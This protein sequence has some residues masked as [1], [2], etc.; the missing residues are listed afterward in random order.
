MHLREVVRDEDVDVAINVMLESFI[1]SQKFSVAKMIRS[2][3]NNY[4]TKPTDNNY[5]LYKILNKIQK[6]H[7]IWSFIQIIKCLYLF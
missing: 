7:V 6:E 3:F 1:Q 4:L 2:K 5:V